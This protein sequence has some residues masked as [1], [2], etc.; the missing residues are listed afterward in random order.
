MALK[1]NDKTFSSGST[2]LVGACSTFSLRSYFIVLLA[3]PIENRKVTIFFEII[4]E[5]FWNEGLFVFQSH[6]CWRLFFGP[7]R[8]KWCDVV[9]LHK[10][11]STQL[12]GKIAPALRV[13]A[14]NAPLR[15]ARRLF[16]MTKPLSS[17]LDWCIFSHNR[18]GYERQT[19]PGYLTGLRRFKHD[20]IW[21]E[22]FN[23][24]RKCFSDTE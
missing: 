4:F 14:E 9:I 12:G 16:R 18:G 7:T 17:R 22:T 1:D 15:V 20:Q 5:F 2:C 24:N 23:T 11:F 10:S 6:H 21:G 3:M 13:E 8:R 19:D